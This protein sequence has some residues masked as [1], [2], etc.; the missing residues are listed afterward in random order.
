MHFKYIPGRQPQSYGDRILEIAFYPKICFIQKGDN[1]MRDA[2]VD[3][4]Y[5][6]TP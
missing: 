3:K 2:Y 5:E 4:F 1:T 6:P